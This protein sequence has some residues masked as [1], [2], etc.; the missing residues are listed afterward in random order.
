MFYGFNQNKPSDQNG[1]TFFRG[2]YLLLTKFEVEFFVWIYVPRVRRIKRGSVSY[3]TDQE[4]E[5]SKIVVTSLDSNR[6]R[7]FQFKQTFESGGQLVK[8]HPLNGPMIAQVVTERQN[9][10]TWQRTGG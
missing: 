8:Y 4:N 10:P 3:S 7:R 5:L 1:Q 2:K 6:G 9:N